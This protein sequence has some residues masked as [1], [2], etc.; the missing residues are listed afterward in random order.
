M[1]GREAIKNAVSDQA[2][3]QTRGKTVYCVFLKSLNYC[4]FNI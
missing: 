4:M 1:S 2:D 3:C